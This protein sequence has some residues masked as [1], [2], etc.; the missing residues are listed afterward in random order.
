MSTNERERATLHTVNQMERR[1][2]ERVG[3]CLEV[4]SNKAALT[5]DSSYE[6][7]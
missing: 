1:V 6:R 4:G 2:G 3:K 7:Y 5:G